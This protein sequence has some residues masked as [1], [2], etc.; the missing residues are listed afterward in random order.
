MSRS[1]VNIRLS[2]I[3][4]HF[5][6]LEDP[7]STINRHHPLPSVLT[8]SLMGVLAGADGPTGISRWAVAK[9]D[10]LMQAL[11]LPHGLPSRDVIRRV[12]SALKV[13]AFQSC[14]ACW[15]NSLRDAAKEKAGINAEETNHVAI[16]GKTMR[17]SHD[18]AKGLGPMHMVSAWL[19]EFGLTLGQV[20]TEEKSNE[21]TAIPELL[22]LID[23]KGSVITIDAMGTQV[24]IAEQIVDGEGDFILALK[25]NQNGL[26]QQVMNCVEDHITD[27]FVRLTTERLEEPLKKSHGRVDTR[28]YLQFEVPNA[29]T[30]TSRWKGLKTIGMVVYKSMIKGEE[31][32]D[33]RYFISSL[34]LDIA[35][36]SKAVRG[37]WGIETTCH[38]SLDVTY[39][40]D[41]LR[42]RQRTIAENLAWLRRFTLSLLKQ[43]PG[44]DSLAMKRRIC[45]WN[46]DF[47]MQVL[48]INAI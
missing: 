13:D 19:S 18:R 24:A 5:E 25:A 31:R 27:D 22:K 37:H 11:D 4:C 21:I 36:F 28:M 41:G 10:L 30:G 16:D 47:L 38:W 14:F 2:E 17:R 20:A 23:L 6:Q 35:Q 7:R 33:I 43:H 40:E 9:K 45:G 12:L 32:I 29:F 48:G 44:K 3:V 26:F 8:I 42:T 46:D 34:S 15:L 1:D 39:G